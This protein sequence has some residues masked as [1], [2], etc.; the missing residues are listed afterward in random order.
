MDL[1]QFGSAIILT[2]YN[3]QSGTVYGVELSG[4]YKEGG[5]S[6][7]AN[8]SWVR[9]MAHGIDTQQFNFGRDE[10]AFIASHNIKLDHESEYSVSSGAAYT[11][12]DNR[13]YVDMIYGSGLRAGFANTQQEPQYYPVNIG[14][15]H[16]FHTDGPRGECRQ[17]SRGYC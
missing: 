13:V 5:F 11:W 14:Y 4:V 3:Y 7:F 15:E 16:V 9:T 17:I 2:P 8:F 6:A 1:G 10:L 12:K